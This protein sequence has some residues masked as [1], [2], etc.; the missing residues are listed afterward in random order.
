M[1]VPAFLLAS[2]INL[3][4]AQRLVRKLC[5][6][7]KQKEAFNTAL[8]P[9]NYSPKKIP[10]IHYTACGCESCYY[11]G[12][13]GRQAVYEVIPIDSDLARHIKNEDLQVNEILSRKG[14]K[15]LSDAAFE[16]FENGETT[17]DEIYPILITSDY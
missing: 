12:Y 10:D 1:E 7:C 14:I 17:I 9:K 4:V 13:K 8:L 16:L 2:T 6:D 15:S 3:S 11:T 5:P